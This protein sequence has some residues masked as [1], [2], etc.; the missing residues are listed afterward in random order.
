LFLEVALCLEPPDPDVDRFGCAFCCE[1]VERCPDCGFLVVVSRRGVAFLGA[2]LSPV[3][4]VLLLDSGAVLSP[5][6][7]VLFD[8]SPAFCSLVV[9]GLDIW[10]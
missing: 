8:E 9:R 6:W 5:V 2:V 3:W 10:R 1:P 7:P 4:P